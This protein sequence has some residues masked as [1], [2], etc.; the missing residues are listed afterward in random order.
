MV[1]KMVPE[2]GVDLR[3][4]FLERLL[5]LLHWHDHTKCDATLTLS[6]QSYQTFD[7]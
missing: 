5:W 1:Q 4:R 2:N 3:R 6:S 7:C